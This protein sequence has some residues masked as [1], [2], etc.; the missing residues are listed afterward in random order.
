LKYHRTLK[1]QLKFQIGRLFHETSSE[2]F[3]I[4]EIIESHIC[5]SE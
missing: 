5:I 2:H 4:M 3:D 1:R